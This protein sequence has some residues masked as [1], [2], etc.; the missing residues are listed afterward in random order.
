MPPRTL[1]VVLN[2][3]DFQPTIMRLLIPILI[4]LPIIAI[5]A[6]PAEVRTSQP[7]EFPAVE[8]TPLRI[9]Q[10]NL[11]EN[12]L[13]IFHVNYDIKLFYFFVGTT[14]VL[15]GYV[16]MS[17]FLNMYAANKEQTTP[18]IKTVS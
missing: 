5:W 16:M 15:L 6:A 10:R 12:C 8:P 1:N 18:T 3:F 4:L 14:G 9:P 17:C 11:S 2:N 13:L 7:T